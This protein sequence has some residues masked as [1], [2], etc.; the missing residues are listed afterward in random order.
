[1]GESTPL[2][3]R[4]DVKDAALLAELGARTF[5]ETFADDNKSED[6]AAYLAAAFSPAKQT[7]ELLDAL[8]L[9]LIAEIDDE[10]V[11]YAQ[12]NGG[13]APECVTGNAPVE[14]VRF[15]VIRQWHGRGVSAA[16]MRACI[17]EARR[18]GYRTM[19]LGVWE[20]NGRAQAFYRKW[21]FQK[22]GEHIFQL[23]S[24]PQ[25]DVL[26]AMK[27]EGDAHADSNAEQK[28]TVVT[29]HAS[30]TFEVKL[31]PQ[32][33][34]VGEPTVG[35][36][37]IDKQF[38]GDLEAVSRGQML[39]T[40]TD[41]EGSAGYVA[42][43]RVTGTLHGRKGTFALQHSGTLTRGVSQLSVTVIPDSG[44]GQLVGLAGKM[45]INIADGKHSYEFE[46]TLDQPH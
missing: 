23:G 14:L 1:M 7:E 27:I 37:T 34:K 22:V 33:D 3:R 6:M 12:L 16:L 26:M 5:S 46:Y 35:R 31:N 20:H 32:E 21:S 15:Y 29:K 17:D 30:G 39:A 9:Y 10:A 28:E 19:W 18:A 2:I 36:M 24:D 25:N 43:E 4:A 45:M 11:A 42:I 41:V 40:R 38:R 13:V 44:T 8:S